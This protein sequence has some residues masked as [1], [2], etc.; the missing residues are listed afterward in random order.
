MDKIWDCIGMISVESIE[1]VTAGGFRIILAAVCGAL[2]GIER[3][4][5]HRPA[6]LR[7]HMLVCVA[8]ALIMI[9]N[10]QLIR[11]YGTGDPTRL[12]AQ[13][14]SGIGFLGAGTILTDKQNRIRGLTT[15]AGLWA[16]A[17]VGLAIGS[18]YYIGGIFTC[19]FILIIFTKFIGIEK[20]IVK[21]SRVMEI[22]VMFENAKSLNNFISVLTSY[23]CNVVSFEQNEEGANLLIELPSNDFHEEIVRIFKKCKG[24]ISI[25]EL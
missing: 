1:E 14:V 19:I 17:C 25:E 7:T 11:V 12:G 3:G 22:Q 13:V 18:G 4:K 10:E 8:S 15:A 6:G 20:H 5:K 9:T 16:S 24:R 2:I 21:K 23:D